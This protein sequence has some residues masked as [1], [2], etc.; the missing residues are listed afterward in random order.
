MTTFLPQPAI[1]PE[2]ERFWALL[3][4]GRFC[5]PHCQACGRAHW[6]PRAFCPFCFS[7]EIEARESAG[8]A[9]VYS[10]SVMNTVP[11][12]VIAYVELAEGPRLMTNL[13]D[14][15]VDA[16]RIGMKVKPVWRAAQGGMQ[17]PFYTAA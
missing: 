13:V 15:D 5:V 9:T 11:P 10:F 3:G 2:T 14:I 16:I 17:V 7:D 8:G 4:K 12:L 6:Y 1:N